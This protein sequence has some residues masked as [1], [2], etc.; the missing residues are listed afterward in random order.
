M[1]INNKEVK[2]TEYVNKDD[3]RKEY[4]YFACTCSEENEAY[5]K[6]SLSEY[7]GDFQEDPTSSLIMDLN[8][9]HHAYVKNIACDMWFGIRISA[10]IGNWVDSQFIPEKECDLFI[11]CDI[12][13]Y[14]LLAAVNIL[15]QLGYGE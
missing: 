15:Q 7:M 9:N 11:Q 2:M 14:G 1:L 5:W 13:P 6:D 8:H 10:C 4:N 3:Q 12:I